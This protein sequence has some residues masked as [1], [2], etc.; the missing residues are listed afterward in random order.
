VGCLRGTP[1]Y[2]TSKVTRLTWAILIHFR[3]VN[4]SL[5]ATT[6]LS[7]YLQSR[8]CGDYCV[9]GSS[10]QR[11]EDISGFAV[12]VVG[13]SCRKCILNNYVVKTVFPKGNYLHTETLACIISAHAFSLPFF[14]SPS[15]HNFPSVSTL[16]GGR[17]GL[18]LRDE[19]FLARACILP[20][21]TSPA[22]SKHSTV[23]RTVGRSPPTD[24]SSSGAAY[25]LDQ[26]GCRAGR[27]YAPARLKPGLPIK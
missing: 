2:R 12:V 7:K 27:D 17:R 26:S 22:R 8:P 23:S 25:R 9:A 14:I 19:L 15:P 21:T 3:S 18:P 5:L 6:Y 20:L 10:K 1:S 4:D 11:G 13:S 24:D 16:G